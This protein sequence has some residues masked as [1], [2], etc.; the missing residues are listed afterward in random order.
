VDELRRV[1]FRL[2]VIC[3][4]TAIAVVVGL[5]AYTRFAPLYLQPPSILLV[6]VDTLRA[7]YLGCYGFDG[8]ISPSIDELA[9]ESVL[10][11]KC[12][13][14]APWTTPSLASMMTSIM[15][16]AHGVALSPEAPR[17]YEAWRRQWTPAI[18]DA[19]LTLAEVLGE[20]GYRTAAFVS[21][22][23]LT[24]DLGFEQGF[25][26]FDASAAKK[27]GRAGS[28]VI[29]PAGLWLDTVLPSRQPFFLYLHLM[30]VHGP[31][32][33]PEGDFNAVR[34]SPGLGEPRHLKIHEFDRI[35]PYLRRP[36]W[37]R[38]PHGKELRTWRGRY[39]A[40]VHAADRHLGHLLRRLRQEERWQNT[41]VVL[42]AD[43]GEELFDHGG[44]DHGFSL[45]QHQLHVPLLIRY[46]GAKR[47]G[48]RV[49]ELVRLV[50]LMPTLL[51]IAEA[52]TPPT[53]VGVDLAPRTH[54]AAAVES[55]PNIFATS[56]KNRPGRSSL[57]VGRYK[58]IADS[59]GTNTRLFDLVNDPEERLDIAPVRSDVVR[60]L[61][62]LLLDE[63]MRIAAAAPMA[64]ATI[65]LPEDQVEQLRE[66]GYTH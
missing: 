39:A 38:N 53:A 46:P 66:L 10:F 62:I 43:H 21:N 29:E 33:A 37:T 61:R 25:D 6:V 34:E 50:D 47:G 22:P 65:E 4:A 14:Q 3:A 24:R 11:E 19:T 52:E 45:R 41:L 36:Q 15:P 32:N 49:G 44:W 26:V 55:Q 57:T 12:F 5:R 54:L 31:Y 64:S 23:F 60:E 58:L 9:A 7:D 28:A 63:L 18:P 17:D 1:A 30:D 16:Q 56:I 48:T 8:N 27:R 20:K 35:Q 13:S 2:A 40:G 51:E 59:D 42:T